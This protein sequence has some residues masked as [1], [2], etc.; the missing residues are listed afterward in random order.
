MKLKTP[1]FKIPGAITILALFLLL[2]SPSRTA[3][4]YVGPGLAFNDNNNNLPVGAYQ[5]GTNYKVLM[6]FRAVQSGNV[7]RFRTYFQSATT[8]S[9][10]S[11]GT[12]G[13][14][15]IR[16]WPSNDATP[17]MPIRTG[18][19]I[20]QGQIK[21]SCTNGNMA[22][23]DKWSLI[24]LTPNASLTENELYFVEI[25]NIDPSPSANW[26]SVNARCALLDHR[27]S[28]PH[29]NNPADW[30][31]YWEDSSIRNVSTGTHPSL[32]SGLYHFPNAEIGYADGTYQGFIRLEPGNYGGYMFSVNSSTRVRERFNIKNDMQITGVEIHASASTAG[33]LRVSFIKNNTTVATGTIT[34][35]PARYRT[36][37]PNTN[38]VYSWYTVNLSSGSFFT[39]KSG[40]I[41]DIEMTAISPAVWRM[42]AD[43]TGVGAFSASS[44]AMDTDSSAQFWNGSAWV[45]TLYYNHNC[46]GCSFA[47]SHFRTILKTGDTTTTAPAPPTNLRIVE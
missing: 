22:L 45:N 43:R 12:C 6:S 14:M 46:T 27:T 5:G 10:Y 28:N 38:G 35:S 31:L 40:D 42:S 4:D 41:L 47:T 20:S 37:G 19:P 2:T 30:S 26:V 32:Y 1:F 17:P 34:E 36:S 15:R 39:V 16:I 13:T 23:T 24:T 21:F 33:S 44:E 18:T 8:G 9:G 11:A 7:T 25:A 29:L 3:A